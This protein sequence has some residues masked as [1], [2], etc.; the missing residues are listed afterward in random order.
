[1]TELHTVLTG[2]QVT[3]VQPAPNGSLL[4]PN[5]AVQNVNTVN[6]S[7]L[8]NPGKNQPAV[9]S[10]FARVAD[11]WTVNAKLTQVFPVNKP[12]TP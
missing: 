7:E 3:Y 4:I 9:A 5:Q 2:T 10:T 12:P 1:M 8:D 6:T 11:P